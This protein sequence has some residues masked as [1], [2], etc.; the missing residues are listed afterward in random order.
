MIQSKL[1]TTTFEKHWI[2]TYGKFEKLIVWLFGKTVETPSGNK[3]TWFRGKAYI[4][5]RRVYHCEA[6]H[7]IELG[8]PRDATKW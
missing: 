1:Q 4:W 3:I 2:R 6:Q 8:Q 5:Q 7:E